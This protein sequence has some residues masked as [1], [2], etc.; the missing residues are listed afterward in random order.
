[1]PALSIYRCQLWRTK[2]AHLA[3]PQSLFASHH[4]RLCL[5]VLT[6]HLMFSEQQ[7]APWRRRCHFHRLLDNGR[8][9]DIA[10]RCCDILQTGHGAEEPC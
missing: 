1:M 10:M 7:P 3:M 9:S 8:L 4:S 5:G 6:M 2:K